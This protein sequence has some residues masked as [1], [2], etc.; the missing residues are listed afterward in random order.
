VSSPVRVETRNPHAIRTD[1]EFH[2]LVANST[3][4]LSGLS[5]LI[6]TNQAVS[7][8]VDFAAKTRRLSATLCRLHVQSLM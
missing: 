4:T 5:I 2:G 3:L 7:F 8:M 6:R 1:V